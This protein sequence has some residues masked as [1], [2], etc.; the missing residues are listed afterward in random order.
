MTP[1]DWSAALA[2]LDKRPSDSIWGRDSG[3]ALVRRTSEKVTFEKT[4][5]RDAGD[6][7]LALNKWRAPAAA[8][9][10][11]ARERV[12]LGTLLA[13]TAM[14]GTPARADD[15][16]THWT[17]PPASL[18]E[19]EQP[20][21]PNVFGTV[22]LPVRA[23]QTSTRWT[24]LMRAS[25]DQ[26]ALL[27]LASHAQGLTQ[28]Q[29]AAYVQSAVTQALRSRADS[30]DC[31]DDGYWA[32]GG[33]TLTRGLGDCFDIAIAKMEALRSLGFADK[34]LYLTTG[35]FHSRSEPGIRRGTAALLVRIA[36]GF[37]LLPDGTDPVIAASQPVEEIAEFSPYITYGDR[38]TWVHGRYVGPPSSAGENAEGG[39]KLAGLS[40]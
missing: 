4:R 6:F 13:A 25:L 30:H 34:D 26:P 3:R 28:Q 24:K 20:I 15:V 14:F 16:V 10:G 7:S 33:E 39:G 23:R 31:A 11:G 5:H 9:I 2:S 21:W 8:L 19:A 32:T 18:A 38:M 37:W 36:D 17:M 1:G 22:A 29:Q 40:R 27:R 35:Y 12:L